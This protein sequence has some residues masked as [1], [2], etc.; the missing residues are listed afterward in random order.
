MRKQKVFRIPPYD[1]NDKAFIKWRRA[2]QPSRKSWWVKYHVEKQRQEA[3]EAN[4]PR[5]ER[6]Q[7]RRD[8][9][10]KAEWEAFRLE[11]E[12]IKRKVEEYIKAKP[13]L[14]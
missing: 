8:A 9:K 2:C 11:Q 5:R 3:W 13:V 7:A 12:A 10:A 6:E 4:R 1:P 14:H